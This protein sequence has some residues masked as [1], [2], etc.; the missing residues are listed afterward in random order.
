[1]E[2]DIKISRTYCRNK[3]IQG[4]QEHVDYVKRLGRGKGSRPIIVKFTVFSQDW[5]C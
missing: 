2:K 3:G 5:K 1:M 4:I